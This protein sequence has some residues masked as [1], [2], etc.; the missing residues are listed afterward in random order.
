MRKRLAQAGLAPSYTQELMRD[1][2]LAVLDDLYAL[3]ARDPA[4]RSSVVYVYES[5]LGFRALLAH[6]VAHR[7]Y[8]VG[9]A[10]PDGGRPDHAVAI[11]ARRIAETAKVT[12][13]IEIHPAAVI[14]SRTVID[15]GFGTVIGEQ[16]RIGTDCYLLHNVVLGSRSIRSGPSQWTGRRHPVVGDRV[17][18]AGNVGVYG[19]VTIGDD[20][21]IEAGARITEDVPAGSRVRVVSVHQTTSRNDPS[22]TPGTLGAAA[23]VR[24]ARG[25]ERY[26]P[27]SP[28]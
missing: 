4:A 1:V 9:V 24:D 5:Y 18:I 27:G 20:C 15:H 26:A 2:P 10:M 25:A 23:V 21:R 22:R 11:A 16:V 12:T 28:H 17:E 14:G 19:P 7:L 13:G 6:R 3:A 8:R